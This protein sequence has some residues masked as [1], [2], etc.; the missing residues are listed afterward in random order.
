MTTEQRPEFSQLSDTNFDRRASVCRKTNMKGR[1]V[2]QLV[3]EQ[4]F[5]SKGLRA[6]DPQNFHA[7]LQRYLILEVRQ[8]VHAFYGHVDTQEAKYPGLDYTHP[9]H[10]IRLSRWPWHR[11][12][13]RA[14]DALALTHAEISSL[15]K[16][17]G[18][19][20]A[21][22]RFEREQGITIRDTTADCMSEW[23]EPEDRPTY[24]CRSN[25]N[26]TNGAAEQALEDETASVADTTLDLP[27][28][29]DE[30][31]ESVGEALNERLRLRVALRNASGDNS[32]SLDEDWEAWLKN[33]IESGELSHFTA[34]IMYDNLRQEEAR[35][36]VEESRTPGL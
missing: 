19:K 31:L 22:E 17:E 13:F 28:E 32:L 33:A 34:Q 1:P 26:A 14:F 6:S 30:E 36:A 8:E 23:V 3:F 20:W 4:I 35:L 7:L 21:K 16:W 11:R 10:R 12:L 9:T 15:T 25:R 27:D 18:T 29:S 5:S 24:R 2:D